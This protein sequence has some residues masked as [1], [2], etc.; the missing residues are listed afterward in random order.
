MALV[1]HV[2]GY[3]RDMVRIFLWPGADR[4]RLFPPEV[5]FI[6]QYLIYREL[7]WR[8]IVAARA[9]IAERGCRPIAETIRRCREEIMTV[10]DDSLLKALTDVADFFTTHECRDLLFHVQEQRPAL[11]PV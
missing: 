5:L 6:F 9:L 8:N 1:A 10:D 2:Y 7:A 3:H 11:T 4:S